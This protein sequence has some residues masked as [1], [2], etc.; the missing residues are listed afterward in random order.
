VR[1]P[2]FQQLEETRERTGFWM[3]TVVHPV[4]CGCSNCVAERMERKKA[5]AEL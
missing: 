4:T 5:G 3:G 1:K 2:W